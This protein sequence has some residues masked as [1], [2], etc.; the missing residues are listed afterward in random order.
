MAG[1][2]LCPFL[3][4]VQALPCDLADARALLLHRSESFPERIALFDPVLLCFV[5]Q[6]F[7]ISIEILLQ[8]GYLIRC[9]LRLLHDL[10][11]AGIKGTLELAHFLVERRLHSGHER[12]DETRLGFLVCSNE[13][14]DAGLLP[15]MDIL[16]HSAVFRDGLFG[17]HN[18]REVGL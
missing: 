11:H 10:V 9:H 15:C 3:I 8:R 17:I 2:C 18:G 7:C 6:D 14:F 4:L 13:L 12:L 5:A 16:I 1:K